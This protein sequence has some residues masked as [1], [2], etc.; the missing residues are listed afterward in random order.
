MITL[1]APLS[2]DINLTNRCNLTCSFCSATPFA[3]TAKEAE[4]STSEIAAV[5]DDAAR[6]GI[7]VLRLGGGEP[8]L[9]D[10]IVEVFEASRAFRFDK[11]LMTNGLLLSKRVVSS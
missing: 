9:R 6:M 5:F 4:L 10:D 2:L 3:H 11:L 1:S 8:L 7:F